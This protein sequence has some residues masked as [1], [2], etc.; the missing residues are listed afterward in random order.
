MTRI[1]CI[2]VTELSDKHLLAEYRELP[3][4]F[5][6]LH[7]G[8]LRGKRPDRYVLGAG[9]VTF[10]ADKCLYLIERYNDLIDEMGLRGFQVNQDMID[11][12]LRKC[13]DLPA[14]CM[15]N[16]LPDNRSVE[17]NRHRIRERST[18]RH[19][20]EELSRELDGCL[21]LQT[22]RCKNCGAKDETEKDIS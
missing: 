10:F 1:N 6:Q 14:W 16:W 2:P 21:L 15:N 19:K 7:K 22:M 9:H 12:I 5:T 18:C 4:I 13:E 3:R 17:I 11:S 20:W 8:Q